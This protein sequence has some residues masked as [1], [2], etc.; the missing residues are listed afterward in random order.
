MRRWRVLPLRLTPDLE[1]LSGSPVDIAR[2]EIARTATKVLTGAQAP[3]GVGDCAGP[4]LGEKL[5]CL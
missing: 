5:S 1:Q 4:N 3:G 2:A